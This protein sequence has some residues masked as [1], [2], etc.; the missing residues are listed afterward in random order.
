LKL[1]LGTLFALI[2]SI[3]RANTIKI[4]VSILFHFKSND[5]ANFTISYL[6]HYRFALANLAIQ[7]VFAR[8]S[9]AM[10]TCHLSRFRL[11]L[12]LLYFFSRFV[13]VVDHYKS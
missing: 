8:R 11:S 1:T 5:A 6:K 2:L 12:S 10:Q 9:F 7:I 13:F 3:Q 4:E